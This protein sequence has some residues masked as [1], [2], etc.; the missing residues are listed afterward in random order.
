MS[1]L[2]SSNSSPSPPTLQPTH[3]PCLAFQSH[4]LN[5]SFLSPQR[6]NLFT[7]NMIK[8]NRL[9][10]KLDRADR[11]SASKAFQKRATLS[12]SAPK[13]LRRPCR[14]QTAQGPTEQQMI[15]KLTEGEG[16]L[17]PWREP[18][19]CKSSAYIAPFN[20]WTSPSHPTP[21]RDA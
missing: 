16:F 14:V 10:V 1:L 13:A 6:V 15:A 3:D 7:L 11:R 20:I 2:F 21:Y 9:Q 19:E 12:R 8:G 17:R 5:L 18:I 4:P